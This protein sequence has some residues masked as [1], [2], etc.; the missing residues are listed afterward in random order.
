MNDGAITKQADY[1]VCPS[2]SFSLLSDKPFSTK[3]REL[4]LVFY[5]F[6]VVSRERMQSSKLHVYSVG[7]L[8][9]SCSNRYR[10]IFGCF[11]HL[12]WLGRFCRYAFILPIFFFPV[13]F[14]PTLFNAH[15]SLT[16]ASSSFIFLRFPSPVQARPPASSRFPSAASPPLSPLPPSLQPSPTQTPTPLQFPL[17]SPCPRSEPLLPLLPPL[18]LLGRVAGERKSWEVEG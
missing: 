8:S 5:S 14:L 17:P 2:P 3:S 15:R 10:S 11:P 7:H 9:A 16:L 13:S 18:R 4:T 12:L 1:Q 6:R